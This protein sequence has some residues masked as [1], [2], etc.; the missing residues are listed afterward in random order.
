LLNQRNKNRHNF[1]MILSFV[2]K[3][4]G[5]EFARKEMHNYCDRALLIIEPFQDN[6]IKSSL[7]TFVDYTI[8]RNK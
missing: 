1:N 4:G 8:L 2:E 5:I 3:N 6:E 7:R